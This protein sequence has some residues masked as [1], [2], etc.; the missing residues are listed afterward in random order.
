MATGVRTS[1]AP[2]DLQ[3]TISR[4]SSLD[5]PSRMNAA[6]ALRRL[7]SAEAVPALTAAVQK[8]QDEFVRFRAFIV[9]SSFADRGTGDLVRGLLRDANDRLREVA[10]KWLE[11]HPD[12]AMAPTLLN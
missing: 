1:Q 12:P 11:A 8:H 7:P 10:Y 9:L 2:A 6:R 4:L 5:Y 3:G